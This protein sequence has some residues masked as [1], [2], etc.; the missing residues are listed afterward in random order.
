MEEKE[1]LNELSKGESSFFDFLDKVTPDDKAW[2]GIKIGGGQNYFRLSI[3]AFRANKN[4]ISFVCK[5]QSVIS[6]DADAC[7]SYWGFISEMQDYLDMYTI[8]L[9]KQLSYEW[10]NEGVVLSLLIRRQSLEQ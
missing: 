7:K 2:A 5:L 1:F 10:K 9:P 8:A 3:T 6:N 4:A